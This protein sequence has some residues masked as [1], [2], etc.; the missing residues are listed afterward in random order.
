MMQ[1]FPRHQRILT[2]ILATLHGRR[3][4]PSLASGNYF[5]LRILF[6]LDIL[7]SKSI[8]RET[9]DVLLLSSKI[10]ASHFYLPL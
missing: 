10:V 5:L 1:I 7:K 3:S 9:I 2:A 4:V 6:L 8:E